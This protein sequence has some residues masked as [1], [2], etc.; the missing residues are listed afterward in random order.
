MVDFGDEF[1]S[2]NGAFMDT[3]AIMMN[4]DLVIS[5]DTSVA[6]LAGSLGVPVWVGLPYV[7][8]W[9]WMLDRTNTPWYPTMRLFRQ[10]HG[11]DWTAVI[12]QM[13][14]ALCEWFSR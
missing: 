6:H 7:P 9:R 11:G 12:R 1:D 10:Q 14:E 4:L 2:A 13:H 8:D 3:A 5:C